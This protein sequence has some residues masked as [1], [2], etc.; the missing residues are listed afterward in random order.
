MFSAFLMRQNIQYRKAV[1]SVFGRKLAMLCRRFCGIRYVKVL[2]E[3]IF[4]IVGFVIVGL[5]YVWYLRLAAKWT[6]KTSLSRRLC[7][8]FFGIVFAITALNLVVSVAIG[9]QG[10]PFLGLVVHLLFGGWFFG[11]FAIN[12]E[13]MAPGFFGGLKLTGVA[14]VLMGITCG[15]LIVLPTL[16]LSAK[17]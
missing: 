12:G 5:L 3:I 9:R 11:K 8:I 14:M 7:W 16:F 4:S 10:I 15:G 6:L 1:K 13:K 2:M 17:V